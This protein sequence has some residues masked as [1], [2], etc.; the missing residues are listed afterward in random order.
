MAEQAKA[1][2]KAQKKEKALAKAKATPKKPGRPKGKPQPKKGS[3]EPM[4]K[5]KAK[6][7]AKAKAG[8]PKRKRDVY[9]DEELPSGKARMSSPCLS[10]PSKPASKRAWKP[11]PLAKKSVQSPKKDERMQ[12]ALKA[13]DELKTAMQNV[14]DD[15]F[16]TP[17]PDFGKKIL[18]YLY[19]Y[20]YINR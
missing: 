2:I 10:T 9:S 7:K 17:G 5:T 11:S 12:K 19:V 16:H 20:I 18:D 6:A 13:L 1:E 8:A 4:A 14:A 15:Q 3:K